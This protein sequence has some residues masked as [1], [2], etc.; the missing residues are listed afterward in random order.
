MR[1]LAREGLFLSR[2][3]ES[4]GWEKRTPAAKAGFSGVVFGTA[5]AV[6]FH[7]DCDFTKGLKKPRKKSRTA[8]EVPPRALSP[9]VR[10]CYKARRITGCWALASAVL[11]SAWTTTFSVASLQHRQPLKVCS[12]EI[13]QVI[14]VIHNGQD[15]PF[16]E[17]G[18]GM[19]YAAANLIANP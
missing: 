4:R 14:G 15:S 8:S 10:I 19:R 6:P 13:E 12:I 1:A 16:I 18:A 11:F 17:G 7:K 9:G 2:A 3:R 5:E